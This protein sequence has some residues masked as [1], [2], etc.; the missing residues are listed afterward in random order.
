VEFKGRIWWLGLENW[1]PSRGQTLRWRE[2]L[3]ALGRNDGNKRV[4]KIPRKANASP[5]SRRLRG[6][7]RLVVVGIE[8]F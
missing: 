4:K 2:G 8:N 7:A 1:V 5:S 3:K 6:L